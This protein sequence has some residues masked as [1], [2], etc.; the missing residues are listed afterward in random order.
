MYEFKE[1][2]RPKRINNAWG[3][4]LIEQ[5]MR[6]YVGEFKWIDA[7]DEIVDW[8]EDNRSMGLVC[9]GDFGL[10]KTIICGSILTAMFDEWKWDYISVSAYEL[11]QK[12]DEIKKHDLVIIDD[13]GVEGEAVIY[14]ERRHI[15]NEIVDYAEKNGTLLIL[16]TN[17]NGKEL[18]KKYGIRTLD[19]LNHIT[20]AVVFHG[21][22][23]RKPNTSGK[24]QYVFGQCF[25][26]GEDADR[27]EE[28]QMRIR[29]GLSEGRFTLYDDWARDAYETNEALEEKNGIVFKY[30]G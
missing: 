26:N 22:S 4:E 10:G 23:E 17:L 7:Y 16:T 15:F 1:R 9:A 8:L 12:V 29:N 25:D 11:S 19:R 6:F 5:G 13:I 2:R 28:E 21:K 3:K 20:R 24:L 30:G 14:G 18:A 27:F